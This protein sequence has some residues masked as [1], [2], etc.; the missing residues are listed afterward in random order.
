MSSPRAVVMSTGMSSCAA[1]RS[2]GRRATR[3]SGLRYCST[4]ASARGRACGRA[5]RP[6]RARQCC[7]PCPPAQR[8][9][10]GRSSVCWRAWHSRAQRQQRE[11]QRPV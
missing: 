6:D 5:P 10:S 1:R 7:P 3:G 4:A 2:P 11:Q 9:S 8:S